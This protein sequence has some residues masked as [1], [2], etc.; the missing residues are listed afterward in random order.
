MPCRLTP[1]RTSMFNIAAISTLLTPVVPCLIGKADDFSVIH[2]NF[3][4]HFDRATGWKA[5]VVEPVFYMLAEIDAVTVI[6]NE[7]RP[8]PEFTSG[9]EIHIGKGIVGIL[10]YG[11]QK[12]GEKVHKIR[13][14][15]KY[16]LAKIW[17]EET[18]FTGK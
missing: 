10:I 3:V 11:R 16:V 8:A 9:R 12:I 14:R 1:N 18:D 17:I 13:R 6:D 5:G 4:R 2:S 7:N 15:I